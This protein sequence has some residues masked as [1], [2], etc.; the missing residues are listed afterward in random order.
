MSAAKPSLARTKT[1][2]QI[3]LWGLTYAHFDDLA[4]YLTW[5]GAAPR[6]SVGNSLIKMVFITANILHKK[7]KIL[8]RH[9]LGEFAARFSTQLSTGFV[10]SPKGLGR[11]RI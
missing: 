11:A 9:G 10:H 5:L 3:R 1:L 8:F 2:L 4:R 6:R 7:A